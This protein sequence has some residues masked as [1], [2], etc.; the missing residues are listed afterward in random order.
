M[1]LN[2]I[3]LFSIKVLTVIMYGYTYLK[4]KSAK[5][6]DPTLKFVLK[7]R[8]MIEFY[9]MLVVNVLFMFTSHKVETAGFY[10]FVGAVL[11]LITYIHLERI[12]AVGRKVLFTRML[13]F[14]IRQI[15]KR[16]YQ[17]GKFTFYIQNGKVD[18]RLPVAD[19]TVVMQM[20]SG[21]RR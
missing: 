16:T 9:L 8:S 18:V 21:R 10:V 13:A 5:G 1:N 4:Y 15:K 20:L 17:R 12:L 11:F 7:G 2:Q 6:L 14:D 19:M 3:V